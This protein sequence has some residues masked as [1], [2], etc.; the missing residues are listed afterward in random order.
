MT[1]E[2]KPLPTVEGSVDIYIRLLRLPPGPRSGPI[3]CSIF[4][5]RLSEA[6]EFE[7]VSY[8]WGLSSDGD[9]IYVTDEGNADAALPGAAL[10]VPG[11]IT[12]F[13]YRTRGHR[14][15][16][17]RTFWID[18][19]CIN[20]RDPK[21]RGVQVPK[22]REIYVTAKATMSWLGPERDRST[23]VIAYAAKLTKLLRKH[24]AKKG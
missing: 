22:M 6:P 5:T 19:I 7:A 1:Y 9:T 8:C 24:M 10:Q 17:T 16:R 12:Q 23:E 14:I 18:S 2:Y 4:V 20:Q 3:N 13:L 15:P 11:S 21:E